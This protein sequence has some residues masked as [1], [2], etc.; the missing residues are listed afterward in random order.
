MKPFITFEGIEGSGKTTQIKRASGFLKR[1]GLPIVLT[2][3]PGGTVFGR[4]I[5]RLVLNRKSY[6]ISAE[7][8]LLLFLSARAQH[9]RQ[10]IKPALGENKIVLCDRFADATIAYQGHGRGLPIDALRAMD[11]FARAS[12]KPDKTFLFDLPPELG[13]KRAMFRIA[14]IDDP[15]RKEDRFEQEDIAFHRRVRNGYL[16]LAQDEPERFIIIDA[17]R[18]VDGVYDDLMKSL[19]PL[20]EG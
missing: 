18:E 13:L 7:A 8:E 15:A 6:T 10:V 3:E 20:I 19:L 4:K 12:L 17:A 9:V 5:R 11:A 1:R 2:E 16:R 14:R